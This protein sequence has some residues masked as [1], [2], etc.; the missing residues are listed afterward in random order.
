MPDEG[1]GEEEGYTYMLCIIP[2]PVGIQKYPPP[3]THGLTAIEGGP[4]G[5]EMSH[6]PV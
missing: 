4:E 6:P 5:Q 2:P 3:L 1:G